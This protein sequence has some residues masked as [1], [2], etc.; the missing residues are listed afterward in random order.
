[1]GGQKGNGGIVVERGQDGG[2]DKQ[3]DFGQRT[4]NRGD[5]PTLEAAVG[6]QSGQEKADKERRLQLDFILVV[7][8]RHGEGDEEEEPGHEECGVMESQHSP[9][10]KA[11]MHEDHPEGNGLGIGVAG[12]LGGGSFLEVSELAAENE[13]IEP[14]SQ[15]DAEHR[16]PS[17]MREHV[18][19][20][21][22]PGV[23]D[24]ED[25]WRGEV[26]EGAADGNVDK[27]KAES[28]VFETAGRVQ[29]VELLAEKEGS[30]GHGGRFSNKR[31]HERGNDEDGE[32]PGGRGTPT[33]TRD[34]A[35]GALRELDDRAA[36]SNR[37]NDDDEN[38]LRV[39]AGIHI[40]RPPWP[41]PPAPSEQARVRAG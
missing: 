1:L 19:Q 32:P 18:G 10:D 34:R 4:Q 16:A 5:P 31:A 22:V 9:G 6:D 23:G 35:Q 17:K 39:V 27:E 30:D 21:P 2:S 20:V 38:G 26:R 8:G 33:Q 15:Q 29:L 36:G 7:A 24:H 11:E 14:R 12:S 25:R 40:E 41:D 28:G 13:E 3:G 37:H